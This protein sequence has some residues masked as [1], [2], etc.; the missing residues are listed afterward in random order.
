[1]QNEELVDVLMQR[2]K[3]AY[4]GTVRTRELE[5]N[6]LTPVFIKLQGTDVSPMLSQLGGFNL[7]DEALVKELADVTLELIRA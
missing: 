7:G 1:M 5:G 3:V 2:F 4:P 6:H